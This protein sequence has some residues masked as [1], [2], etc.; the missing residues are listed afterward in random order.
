MATDDERRDTESSRV[1][2]Q[3]LPIIG[4][5]WAGQ[6]FAPMTTPEQITMNNQLQ[7]D[8]DHPDAIPLVAYMSLHRVTDP[9]MKAAMAGHT[10]ITR[11]TKEK[12]DEIFASFFPSDERSK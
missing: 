5:Q 9:V 4:K 1:I 6:Q 3:K 10:Q 8:Y 2:T 11:A 12:W 7:A